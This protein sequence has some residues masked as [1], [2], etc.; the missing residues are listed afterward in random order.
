MK[1]PCVKIGQV[2]NTMV[3]KNVVT[4]RLSKPTSGFNWLIPLSEEEEEE[5]RAQE[6]N[7]VK[8]RQSAQ[9]VSSRKV[10]ETES[11]GDNGIPQ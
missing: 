4:G 8:Q 9:V 10:K 2:G 7:E 6:T 5:F 3:Y 1:Y 11:R